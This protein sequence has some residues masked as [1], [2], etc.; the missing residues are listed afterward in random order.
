MKTVSELDEHGTYVVL[1]GFEELA[2]I[3]HLLGI[4]LPLDLALG[5]DVNQMGDIVTETLLDIIQRIVSV[6]HHIVQ[7][8]SNDRVRS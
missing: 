2:E 3:L 1:H 7:E 8:G 6:L 5:P 4:D